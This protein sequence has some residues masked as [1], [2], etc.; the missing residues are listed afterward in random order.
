MQLPCLD[1]ELRGLR[2]A[3]SGPY[4]LGWALVLTWDNFANLDFNHTHSTD[5]FDCVSHIRIFCTE[6]LLRRCVVEDTLC[7]VLSGARIMILI[8]RQL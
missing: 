4:F 7:G 2:G 5:I 3:G 8:S 6:A 1:F